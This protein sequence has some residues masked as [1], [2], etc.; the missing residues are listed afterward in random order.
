MFLLNS[1]IWFKFTFT[2]RQTVK[3]TTWTNEQT[4]KQT[5]TTVKMKENHSK[6]EY[7]FFLGGGELT[8]GPS[9]CPSHPHPVDKKV[10]LFSSVGCA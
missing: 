7:H 3:Q 2:N 5:N 4:N 1:Q 8:E 6:S 10:L 9:S